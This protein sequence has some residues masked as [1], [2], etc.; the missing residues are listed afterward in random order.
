[1]RKGEL[2]NLKWKTLSYN[3]GGVQNMVGCNDDGDMVCIDRQ[4]A[5]V[6]QEILD[7]CREMRNNPEYRNPKAEGYIAARV[8]ITLWVNWRRDWQ[9]RYSKYWTWQTYL[10]MKR[11]S[12]EFSQFRCIN[13]KIGLPKAVREAEFNSDAAYASAM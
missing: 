2:S 13:G 10:V 3:E 7:S 12:T 11:N 6:N 1:M 9:S 4:S 5:A 8:P